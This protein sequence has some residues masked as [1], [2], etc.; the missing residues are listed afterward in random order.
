MQP[1][2]PAYIYGLHESGGQDLMLQAGRPGWM[3]ELAEVGHD[4]QHTPSADHTDLA[5]HG[6]AVVVR[7]NHGY[8]STGSIPLPY[9]YDAFAGACAAFLDRRGI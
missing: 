5:N 7:L 4:P 6:L 3:L 9:L 2:Y 1:R 8:R